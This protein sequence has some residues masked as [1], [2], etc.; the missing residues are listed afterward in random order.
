ME[1]LAHVYCSNPT[2]PLVRF[3]AQLGN[4]TTLDFQ[5]SS[6]EY[7][8]SETKETPLTEYPLRMV[9]ISCLQNKKNKIK[10]LAPLQEKWSSSADSQKVCQS[11]N[12]SSYVCATFVRGVFHERGAFPNEIHLLSIRTKKKCLGRKNIATQCLTAE[13]NKSESMSILWYR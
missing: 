4:F 12:R 13:R 2:G 9:H 11:V 10:I 8:I 5:V 1:N 6:L 7:V 3:R